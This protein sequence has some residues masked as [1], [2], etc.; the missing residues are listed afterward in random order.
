MVFTLVVC[1]GLIFPTAAMSKSYLIIYSKTGADIN[2]KNS[3]SF[4]KIITR[5]SLSIKQAKTSII[6]SLN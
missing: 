4:F 2:Y 5:N 3:M 6:N 1:A